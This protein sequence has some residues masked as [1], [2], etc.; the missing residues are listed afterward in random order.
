MGFMA[1]G[2]LSTGIR[3]A[4][5]STLGL[6]QETTYRGSMMAMTTAGM[7]LGGVLGAMLGGYALLNYG[8]AGFG[9]VISGLSFVATFIYVFWVRSEP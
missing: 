1:L 6:I 4:A 9:M 2:S 7:S 5:S 3:L 8:Y